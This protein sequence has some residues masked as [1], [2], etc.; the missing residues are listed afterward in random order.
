MEIQNSKKIFL[1]FKFKKTIFP[2]PNFYPGTIYKKPFVDSYS[3]SRD[4]K[5]Q[6]QERFYYFNIYETKG[7]MDGGNECEIE[8]VGRQKNMDSNDNMRGGGEWIE[9][10]EGE[11]EKVKIK[12]NMYSI[13]KNNIGKLKK[14]RK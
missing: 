1:K 5:I 2:S 11:V 3:G 13:D 10:E 7:G 14:I 6:E 9:G 12:K 4:I 8:K